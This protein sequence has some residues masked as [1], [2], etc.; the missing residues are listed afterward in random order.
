MAI[1]PYIMDITPLC[2]LGACLI[3]IGSLILSNIFKLGQKYADYAEKKFS[4]YPIGI[5]YPYKFNLVAMILYLLILSAVLIIVGFE[6]LKSN[7]HL[8]LY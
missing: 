7:Y 2:L 4:E 8:H 6:I 3:L 5:K 1:T